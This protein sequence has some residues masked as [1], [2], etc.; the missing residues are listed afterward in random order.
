MSRKSGEMMPFHQRFFSSEVQPCVSEQFVKNPINGGMAF[1]NAQCRRTILDAARREERRLLCKVR[2][3]GKRSSLLTSCCLSARI[4]RFDAGAKARRYRVCPLSW[5]CA[6]FFCQ[7]NWN[8][9]SHRSS[10]RKAAMAGAWLFHTGWR[11]LSCLR[12]RRFESRLYQ[13]RHS[14][15][16][17]EEPR[18]VSNKTW[19]SY[20]P[21]KGAAAM[22]SRYAAADSFRHHPQHRRHT[23]RTTCRGWHDFIDS[24]PP[25]CH[26]DR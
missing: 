25:A 24:R 17:G 12:Q 15:R 23:Q 16:R 5:T 22:A 7:E 8:H 21:E 3:S 6:Y 13:G 10:S 18:S 4:F 11:S 14:R 19:G 1:A 9:T 2:S 26:S 20:S